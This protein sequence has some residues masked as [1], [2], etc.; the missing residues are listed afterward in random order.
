MTQEEG[1]GRRLQ[2]GFT[3]IELMVVV[4]IIGIM[5]SI[6]GPMYSNYMLRSN[7]SQVIPVMNTIAAKERIHFNRTGYYLAT[8]YEQQLQQKLGLN[9]HDVGDYC[10]MVFCGTGGT[11]NC[12]TYG[13]HDG[14]SVYASTPSAI[15]MNTPAVTP[16]QASV[17]RQFQVVA[18]LRQKVSGSPTLPATV[19]GPSSTTCHVSDTGFD[20]KSPAKTSPQG[21][22]GDANT[23]GGQGRFVVLSYP[24][25]AD[26]SSSSLRTGADALQWF[27]G[28]TLSD[29]L[30][31]N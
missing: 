13:E 19:A 22:V 6:G 27:E 30:S 4:V 15:T 5:A 20:S 21:W 12:G 28:I 3:L 16:D 18:V 7:L 29:A 23:K 24:T 25:P 2:G 9:L 11:W 26:G 14:K 17:P 8:A 10:F 31:S 1:R